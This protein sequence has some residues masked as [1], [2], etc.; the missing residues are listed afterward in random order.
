MTANVKK[1]VYAMNVKGAALYN[2]E[3]I[4]RSVLRGVPSD[5]HKTMIEDKEYGFQ[6]LEA[7]THWM[8][9][10]ANQTG[11]TYQKLMAHHGL[12]IT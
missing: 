4:K 2:D 11:P 5:K 10:C 6:E 7:I 3:I 1:Y 9:A 12:T 8:E